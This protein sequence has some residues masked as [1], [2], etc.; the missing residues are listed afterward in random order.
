MAVNEF[1][2]TIA[3]IAAAAFCGS[4][5]Q[6]ATLMDTSGQ[7]LAEAVHGNGSQTGNLV[8]GIS[9]KGGYFINFQGDETLSIAGNGLAQINGPFHN[10]LMSPLG[11]PSANQGLIGFSQ[12]Q[13]NVT[14]DISSQ[15]DDTFTVVANF[16]GGGYDEFD[17]VSLV[18]DQQY[19]LTAGPGQ[20]I[21][22]MLVTN[23]VSASDGAN[24]EF[25]D[26]RQIYFDA[27]TAPVPEPAAWTLMLVGVG[28]MGALLRRRRALAAA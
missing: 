10:I 26:L 15:K 1:K 21:Q 5:A 8:T 11:P 17:N 24:Q 18:K 20:V 19:T 9:F 7:P 27:V 13:F 3:S 23:L 16:V 2:I 4:A 6:A 28:G 22:S 14:A 25:G 12:I